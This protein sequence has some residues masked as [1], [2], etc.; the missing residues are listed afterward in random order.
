MREFYISALHLS[1]WLDWYIY[2]QS[3]LLQLREFHAWMFR[4]FTLRKLAGGQL[5]LLKE[6]CLKQHM[7]LTAPWENQSTQVEPCHCKRKP[8]QFC[9][10][11]CGLATRLKFP[12]HNLHLSCASQCP[13]HNFWIISL[14]YTQQFYFSVCV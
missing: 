1:I 11:N 3:T 13:R 4:L 6:R 2:I 5:N 9:N 12:P 8:C 10:S 7:N 14:R